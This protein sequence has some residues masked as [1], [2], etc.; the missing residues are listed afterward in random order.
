MKNTAKKATPKKA[1]EGDVL[2]IPLP[3]GM[4][5]FAKVL[6][7]SRRYRNVMLLGVARTTQPSASI[8]IDLDFSAG[9]F[10]TSVVCPFDLGWEIVTRIPLTQSETLRSVRIVAGDVWVGDA[11]V[12]PASDSDLETLPQMSVLACALLQMKVYEFF[13]RDT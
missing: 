11:H 8:P 4:S 9:L 1:K 2:R 12:R 5:A 10:Y 6:Y 13:N 7:A 3:T